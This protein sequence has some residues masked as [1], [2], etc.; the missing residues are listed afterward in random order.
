MGKL[1]TPQK[2]GWQV[3]FLVCLLGGPDRRSSSPSSDLIHAWR[4]PARGLA[5]HAVSCSDLGLRHLYQ[6][7]SLTSM[8]LS[9]YLSLPCE[10]YSPDESARTPSPTTFTMLNYMLLND[11][12]Y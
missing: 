7:S 11:A 6:E 8:V 10:L 2:T 1:V 9:T 3:S 4:A 12:G 5:P